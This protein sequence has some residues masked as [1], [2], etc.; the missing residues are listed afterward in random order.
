MA[1]KPL[2]FATFTSEIELPFYSALFGSKLDHDK[3]DDS[4][5]SVLGLYEPRL[6]DPESSCRM[7]ILGNALT[8]SSPP[9]GTMRAEGIIRNVN[10]LEDFKNMDKSAMIKTAGRQVWDA[11]KDGSIYSVPSLLSSFVILSYADL[12]KYKFTYWFAFPALHSD[13]S[14]K[15]SG[16]AEHLNA[17]ESTALVDR[18]GT[19]RYSVDAREHGFFLAKKV[20][21]AHQQTEDAET[22]HNLPYKWEVGSLRDFEDGFFNE[23]PEEDQYVAFVDPSTYPEGPGWPLR[24]Y[25][26]LIRQRFRLRKVKILCYR[27]TWARRHEARSVI[28]PIEM[29]PVENMEI[30]EM[31]KVT[32]W[33]RSRNGKLQAQQV[34][35]SEYMDPAR[36]ADS[37]VD[38]NLKLMKW[39]IAPNLDLEKIKNTKCLLLGAGTLGSYVS[40]NLM[41]WGVR[42]ITFVDYGRVSFSNP[43]RQ[44]LFEFT[45][46][47]EG[48][49]PKAPRAA[50]VLKQIYPGADSEGHALSVPMLG[51][52]FTDEVKTRGDYEKLA[53]LI[54][55]HDAIFLL[56]DSRESRWLPTVMGKAA[57]KIVMNAA[58]GFDSYVVMRHGSETKV[59]GQTPL[60]CY[61]CNDVVA[62]AD[63]QKDQTLDQQCTVTRPGVAAIASALLV[64]LLTSLLQHPLGKDA[65]APQPTPGVVPERD[66]P[67]HALGLVPHQVRGYVSTFQNIVIRGQSYDCCSAC[68]PK[69]LDAFR[70][71]GWGF[72]KKALQEKDYVAELS[73]L[74]E[75]QRRAEEMAA[76][77][78]WEEDD[79]LVEEEGEGE[80]L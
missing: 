37:S 59:E 17:E 22:S 48:G 39:R 70:K 53:K 45:D 58:L 77:V 12:K 76:Q 21:G 35:L 36:L 41:G 54:D 65:P 6:E 20:H 69:I 61:F 5:R 1:A 78:D 30:T 68:S 29:D 32:G 26:I 28:L 66:P 75:V 44:P 50:E 8:S 49:K 67:D 3:L 40:R 18:V 80:L 57:G 15:R 13:P 27:D 25:L 2:Q 46:C 10:T 34:S 43:V 64:E 62:P 71:D 52:P 31:P 60:G 19:W 4:A 47:L 74:A 24:N 7:Q 51:H 55:E 16:P 79:D 33:E 9:L 63:S 14:W 73:G 23:V 42:K 11:I 72:V 56:M 38:L